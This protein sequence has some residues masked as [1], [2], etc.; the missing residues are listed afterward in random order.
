M[1]KIVNFFKQIVSI[2]H[3][4][5]YFICLML[6]KGFYF[7]FVIFFKAMKTIFKK[8]KFL[9]KIIGAY[10]YKQNNPEQFLILTLSCILCISVYG[11]FFV[12]TNEV[13]SLDS[14]VV[15][16]LLTDVKNE[17]ENVQDSDEPVDVN[18][19]NNQTTENNDNNIND[20]IFLENNLLKTY[21][22][23]SL[24]DINFTNLKNTNSNFVMWL[25]VDGTNI[26]Y[27]IVQTSDNDYYLKRSFDH[28]YTTNGWPF[29]DYR[30]NVSMSD[31]NTIFYGHNLLNKTAFGSIANL[32]TNKWFNE[33]NHKIMLIFENKI[34]EYEIFS[35]YYSEVTDYY[36]K[37]DFASSK[38]FNDFL[39]NIKSKSVF[40]FNVDVSGDD[41]II[42][43]ST[44]TDDNRGR[45]VVHAKLISEVNRQYIFFFF[46]Y[47]IIGDI[48]EE[49]IINTI[50]NT[51]GFTN[52]N[53]D[54]NSK[55][56]KLLVEVVEKE[57]SL[58][59]YN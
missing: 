42:T 52:I 2:T 35:V 49:N 8:F 44:C 57:S 51:G 15:E 30:N 27:P 31:Y 16:E 23:M 17:Y 34:Y 29:L 11:V 48:M 13:V 39:T 18:D 45:K 46:V 59:K 28:R 33:S 55:E 1:N 37:I 21:G 10:E 38:R 3:K 12:N 26:N 4:G 9:D 14:T 58:K 22:A 41:R 54:C 24:S 43:L 40:N 25:L 32:F 19:S 6:S 36:L 50:K 47:I 7:Y 53:V 20:N 56:G 5:F